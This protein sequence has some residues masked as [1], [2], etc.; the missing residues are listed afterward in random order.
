MSPGITSPTWSPVLAK[1]QW[2]S[3]DN[4]AGETTISP[5]ASCPLSHIP[6]VN[7]CSDLFGEFSGVSWHA[8]L[9]AF[10]W[11]VVLLGQSASPLHSVVFAGA[12][13]PTTLHTRLVG[14]SLSALHVVGDTHTP[15]RGAIPMLRFAVP[16]ESARNATGQ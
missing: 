9:H 10:C 4:G 11:H 8:K 14:Q 7:S 15:V 16:F 12:H 3:A 1:T 6:P 5:F 2:L 13:W